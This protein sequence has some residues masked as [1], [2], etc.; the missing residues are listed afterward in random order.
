MQ[1]INAAPPAKDKN[2]FYEKGCLKETLFRY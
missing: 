2:S 1:A